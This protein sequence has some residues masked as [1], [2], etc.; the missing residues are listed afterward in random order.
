MP[1]ACDPHSFD[2]KQNGAVADNP[3][4]AVSEAK[5]RCLRGQLSYLES[6]GCF[7]LLLAKLIKQSGG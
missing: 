2:A 3:S 4:I 5:L 1:G 6:L 7:R